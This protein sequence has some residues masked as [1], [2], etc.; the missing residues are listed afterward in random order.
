MRRR[1]FLGVIGGAAAAAWPVAAQ[2]QQRKQH[3]IGLLG[4]TT[5]AEYEESI[6]TLRRGLQDLGYVEGSSLTIQYK[7][8]EGRYERL[9][10]LVSELV[11]DKVDVIV[12][13][14]TP[15]ARAAKDGT[16]AIPIVAIGASDPV[17]A[18]LVPSLARPGGNLTGL[19]F[20][21]A[22]IRA[23]R[24]EFLKEVVPSVG[25]LAVLVNP[26]NTTFE[27]AVPAMQQTARKLAIEIV[28]IPVKSR[29]EIPTAFASIKRQNIDGMVAIEEPLL[30]SNADYVSQLALVQRLTMIGTRPHVLAGA[31]LA[32]GVDLRD[33]WFRAA[34]YVDRLLN[35]VQ[36]ADLPIEQ[37]VK[38]QTFVNLKTARAL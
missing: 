21:F 7:F 3:R 31:L 9:P 2:A 17:H 12:T 34:Y 20:F 33:L 36:P 35:R 11:R 38:F 23:K 4:L 29:D 5:F 6:N 27:Q 30:N 8:A 16:S 10:G 32:Y 19:T 22:E 13:H 15:G 37:A 28:P 24:V 18:G 26:A 25:R 14:G 1:E